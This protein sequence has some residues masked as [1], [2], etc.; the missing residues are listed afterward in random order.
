M[1]DADRDLSLDE[2][3]LISAEI[4]EGD[5][6]RDAVLAA[7]ELSAGAWRAASERWSYAIAA[8][9]DLADAYAEAFVRAQDQQKPLPAMTPE[10][11]A[12]LVVEVAAGGRQALLRRGLSAADQL[13]LSRHWARALGG[14]KALA[15]RYHE[16][17][18]AA[19][20]KG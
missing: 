4:S 16:A 2:F 15:A 9:D 7:H 1:A 14:D 20:R 13:R 17:F 18:Y 5:R 10:E 19:Q 3:A 12:G 8:D 11:W 6:T